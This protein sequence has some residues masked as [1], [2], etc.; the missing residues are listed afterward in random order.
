M[1]ALRERLL[2]IFN[3]ALHQ[4]SPEAEVDLILLHLFRQKDRQI[5]N[6]SDLR[7]QNPDP[8]SILELEAIRI[9]EKRCTGIPLQHILGIQFFYEHEYKVND[10]TLIPRPETEILADAMIQW[11]RLY[12]GNLPLRFAELGLGSGILSTEIL[13]E[14]KSASGFASEVA[15]AAIALAR[16]NLE[17]IVGA[18]FEKRITILEPND[19]RSGFEIFARHGKFDLI[20]SNPP[21]V[22][23]SDEI[24]DEVLKHEPHGALFPEVGSDSP[25]FFYDNFLLHFSILMSPGGSAFFEVPHERA[26]EILEK[27]KNAGIFNSKLIL[28]LTGRPRVL[29]ASF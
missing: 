22:S 29:Q 8:D 6:F 23:I 18:D 19:P 4:K 11:I 10:S 27:F 16:H 17:R 21:Y 13:A 5:R 9:A 3:E 2:S 28:D 26:E 14:F 7:T 15:P 1:Q 25:D 20:F 24:E 12:K